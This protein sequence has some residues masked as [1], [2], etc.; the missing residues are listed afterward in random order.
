MSIW[1][2]KDKI[3]PGVSKNEEK[4]PAYIRFFKTYF[5]HFPTMVGLN[6]LYL[7]CCL[8]IVTIG[9]STAALNYVMRNYVRGVHVDPYHDF[10]KKCR[11]NFKQG[12]AVTVL[13][14][15]VCIL[16]G[17]QYRG[18]VRSIQQAAGLGLRFCSGLCS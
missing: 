4:A 12:T 9:A 13:Y 10:L 14:I 8:P 3:G 7:F 2:F 5:T 1:S 17:L 11:E 15:I 16:L 18:T 6:L